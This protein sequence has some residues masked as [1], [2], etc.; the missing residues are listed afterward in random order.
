MLPFRLFFLK[1]TGWAF[2]HK[3]Q[4]AGSVPGPSYGI[5]GSIFLS[6]FHLQD[7]A[8]SPVLHHLE[9]HFLSVAFRYCRFKPSIIF[10]VLCRFRDSTTYTNKK[11]IPAFF[12]NP[13]VAGISWKNVGIVFTDDIRLPIFF[14]PSSSFPYFLPLNLS[15][16][17]LSLTYP[18][19]QKRRTQR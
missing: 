7:T 13:A 6:H 19:L 3:E 14:Y 12:W 10:V 2:L 18:K 8:F 5:S 16:P 1:D 15:A 4:S 17:G 9:T 11:T